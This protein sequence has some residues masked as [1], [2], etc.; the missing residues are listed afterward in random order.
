MTE[1]AR[2]ERV[3]SGLVPTSDGWDFVH[4]APGTAHA[5]V[6]AGDGPCVILMTGARSKDKGIV[7]PIRPISPPQSP[8]R[9]GTRD[10][11]RTPGVQAL[12]ALAAGEAR[13][14]GRLAVGVKPTQNRRV[15]ER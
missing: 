8:R 15:S 7:Y 12:P 9:R 5:F 4:R 6:G 11:L 2:L 3:A 14:V 13:R 10:E 1:E